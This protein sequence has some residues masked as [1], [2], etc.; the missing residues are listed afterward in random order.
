MYILKVLILINDS[1]KLLYK[2]F[3]MDKEILVLAIL[4]MLRKG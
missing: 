3:C 2:R 1:N 4:L